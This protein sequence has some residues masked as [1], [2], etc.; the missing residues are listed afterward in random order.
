[1]GPRRPQCS[2][3]RHSV[4]TD[5]RLRDSQRHLERQQYMLSGMLDIVV[6]VLDVF[7]LHQPALIN[8]ALLASRVLG[9][10]SAR[11]TLPLKQALK[12]ALVR[13]AANV[14]FDLAIVEALL[15]HGA[16]HITHQDVVVDEGTR[17]AWGHQRGLLVESGTTPRGRSCPCMT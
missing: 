12:D 4:L 5:A 10:T 1:M 2:A 17:M 14:S 13:A 8:R 11:S 15:A 6:G 16:W 7:W 3:P 9:E